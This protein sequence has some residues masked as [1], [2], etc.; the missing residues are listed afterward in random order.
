LPFSVHHSIVL[1]TKSIK[2][3]VKA[4]VRYATF[5]GK[6]ESELEDLYL[7][8]V[9]EPILQKDFGVT[10]VKPLMRGKHKWSER[11]GKCFPACGQ[12]WDEATKAFV[13]RRV[14]EA[15]TASPKK[16]L[17]KTIRGPFD[18]LVKLL[19]E[20]LAEISRG[21][22]RKGKGVSPKH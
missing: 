11:I 19:E 18:N 2:L 7:Q 4:D 14:A 13:K 6:H 15:V 5:P 22:Y 17:T 3:L 10:L 8:A 20:R 9:Y 1:F 16:A 21:T 12:T